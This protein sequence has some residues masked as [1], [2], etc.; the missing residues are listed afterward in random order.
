MKK[1]FLLFLTICITLASLDLSAQKHKYP[2]V[3]GHKLVFDIT[4]ANDK[5]VYLAIHYRDKLMLRDSAY[6]INN[7]GLFIF[8][9]NEIYDEGLYTLVAEDK[10]PYIN[11]I[12]D[13]GQNF[14]MFLDTVGD[15]RNFRAEN[16]P[17]NSEMLRFQRKS[18]TAQKK[19]QGYQESYKKFKDSN[20]DSADFYY[21]KMED[22]NE[23]MQNFITELIEKNPTFLFSKLQKSYRQ[24]EVPEAPI[25]PNGR[26]DSTFQPYYYRLH[27]WDNFDLTDRRFLFLPSFEPKLKDYFERV[28]FY[29]ETD[30]INK[31]IDLLY[32]KAENDSLM[33]RY[34][35]EW[36]TH[37]F[38]VSKILG[39]DAVFVHIAK[40][41][42]LKGKCKWMDETLIGKYEKRVKGLEPLLIGSKSI[43]LIIPDTTQ[44]DDP[45]H[46]FSSWGMEKPYVILWFY[47]PTCPTCKKESEKLRIVYD[48]LEIIG[49]RNFD[50]YGIGN[51][52]D[53]E[54]WIKYVR[55]KNYPWINVGG[56]KANV[57]FLEA[58]NIYESG[59]PAMFIIDN[60][61]KKIILNKRIEM[62][63][64]PEF[65]EQYEKI[66][67]L[68]RERG[69][70]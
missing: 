35:V 17:Q 26:P 42:Q 53:T 1:I 21:K 50:V 20:K 23:E 8:E 46:W 24:V 34:M 33:Y 10:H 3:K 2:A 6:N 11:F 27:F 31:Y 38:E 14:T 22:I 56:H 59:N 70:Y 39:H 30:T 32:G 41:N 52:K 51:D 18:F 13:G 44:S 68:K 48:S 47:D 43:E 62:S 37:F 54:R 36:T 29:Q 69:I 65:L 5:I 12:I 9:G 58:Y 64:I 55:E 15:V 7:K 60:K 66:Q 25:L 16:S 40:E 49:K 67:A 61:D 63:A 19:V 57:D 45:Q 28:L 4:G